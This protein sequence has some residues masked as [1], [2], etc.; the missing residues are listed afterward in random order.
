MKCVR[1]LIERNTELPVKCSGETF[2]MFCKHKTLSPKY[3]C[4]LSLLIPARCAQGNLS[5]LVICFSIFS[6][7]NDNSKLLLLLFF[8]LKYQ[9]WNHSDGTLASNTVNGF[10]LFP[11]L[12]PIVC[13]GSKFGERDTK[14]H[15]GCNKC[16]CITIHDS[17]IFKTTMNSTYLTVGGCKVT[18]NT[19]KYSLKSF[20]WYT[21]F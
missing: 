20:W 16:T 19:K 2:Y 17:E 21:D 4:M 13:S 5:V 9:F 18:E 14:L 7:K 6:V 3:L 15:Y 10:C 12:P 11:V 8:T 1:L